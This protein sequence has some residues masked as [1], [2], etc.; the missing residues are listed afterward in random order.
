MVG[1]SSKWL[2]SNG[3]WN[4]PQYSLSEI[5]L[6]CDAMSSLS[7]QPT[8]QCIFKLSDKD[9]EIMSVPGAGT[10]LI[11]AVVVESSYPIQARE[12]QTVFVA[13]FLGKYSS[14]HDND[15]Q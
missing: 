14:R 3:A 5:W 6:L 12:P 10:T 8:Y 11:L 2:E 9:V 1:I 15:T 4:S 7:T 13:L